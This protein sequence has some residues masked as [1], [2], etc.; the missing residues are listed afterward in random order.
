MKKI[1]GLTLVFV[2]LVSLLAV[3]PVAAEG[4]EDGYYA[5]LD[6]GIT[7]VHRCGGN[8]YSVSVAAKEIGE[9]KTFECGCTES[10]DN[11]LQGLIDKADSSDA[12]K[13]VAT[14]LLNYGAAAKA[15]FGYTGADIFG[16]PAT[17]VTALKAANA[18]DVEITDPNGIYL[19]ATL[20][21]DGTM[22]IRFF[23]NTADVEIDY[24]GNT[25][26]VDVD[27]DRPGVYY[28]DVNVMPYAM[29]DYAT[30]E[31]T[32][33]VAA[34]DENSEEETD[35][36]TE[37]DAPAATVIKYSP[38]NYLQAKADDP[39][40]S[41]MVASI[42]AYGE[43]AYAYYYEGC[44]VYPMDGIVLANG[45]IDHSKTYSDKKHN[46]VAGG[47][48]K[49]ALI[50]LTDIDYDTVT[51]TP[52]L[53]GETGF[54]AFLTTK[55]TTHDT[56]VNYALNYNDM[57]ELND[58]V[59]LIIPENAKYLVVTNNYDNGTSCLPNTIVFSDTVTP[60]DN[61]K[62]DALTTYE[63]PVDTIKPSQ[64][65][66]HSKS[67]TFISNFDWISSIVSLEDTVFNQ[68]IFE[69]G[70]N[71]WVGYAFLTDYPTIDASIPFA[72]KD[73]NW[74]WIEKEPGTKVAV[75]IP[76]NAT[77]MLLCWHEPADE[78]GHTNFI[79]ASMTFTKEGN[80]VDPLEEL[81]DN[82]LPKYE[83]PMNEV[84]PADGVIFYWKDGHYYNTHD[85]YRVAFIE[86]TGTVFDTVTLTKNLN[87][88]KVGWA[89]L[90]KMPA[91]G[92]SASYATGY[93]TFHWSDEGYSPEDIVIPK[94]ATYLAVYYQDSVT[95]PFC[96]ETITF[97]QSTYS[98]PMDQLTPVDGYFNRQNN[99]S[100][101]TP[102]FKVSTSGEN[103]AFVDLTNLDYNTVTLLGNANNES[104]WYTFVTKRPINNDE[105]ISYA[106]NC[107]GANWFGWGAEKD[108]PAVPVTVTI[109]DNAAY[110]VVLYNYNTKVPT[111]PQSIV[112]SNSD[113]T[114]SEMLKNDT[115]DS[116]EY[117]MDAIKPSMGTIRGTDNVF[118]QNYQWV[119][120]Y[121]GIEDCV[122]DKVTFEIGESGKMYYAF[123]TA[124]PTLDQVVS[125]AGGATSTTEL[126]GAVGEKIS[127]SIPDDAVCLYIY[128]HDW[129]NG[130]PDYMLPA[131]VTFGKM[132]TL[133]KLQDPIRD[134][135]SYP[136]DE[137]TSAGGCVIY[138]GDG[139]NR[140]LANYN[141]E[142]VGTYQCAFIEITD[143]VFNYVTMVS[144]GSKSVGWAF[145]S[146]RPG[147]GEVAQY[148][149]HQ[150]FL[151]SGSD[152]SVNVEI[153][154]GANY[155]A[156]WYIES[157]NNYVPS[158]IL[159]SK[160]RIDPNRAFVGE[161][162]QMV[163]P[164]DDVVSAGGCVIYWD[165]N[166]NT[167]KDGDHLFLEN[168]YNE[169]VGKYQCAVIDISNRSSALKYV[170]ITPNGKKVAGYA[171]LSERPEEGKAV[172]YVG[173]KGFNWTGDKDTAKK[174]ITI[175]SGAKYLVV[176]YEEAGN[177]YCPASIIFTNYKK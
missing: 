90:T 95:E 143:T 160:E 126:T 150:G 105:K 122:F 117:P 25:L 120:S 125:F 128:R 154:D 109:P 134:E 93:E 81:R 24:D 106:M 3:L 124:Y 100:N 151:W 92:E 8:E 60:A 33:K 166:G 5:Y 148:V 139:G 176:W 130:A 12:T 82:T 177:D 141:N 127:V 10:V 37:P 138:W 19:G 165:E 140:F 169:G 79:P 7:L 91:L 107:S 86:I 159:F 20:V 22:K 55:P 71:G 102:T 1:L 56:M 62:N 16:T 77:C 113:T 73:A 44:Y 75:D 89:F 6:Q 158:N 42:Y 41:A 110:M 172:K 167:I 31:A 47:G 145:L 80:V 53:D 13:A 65:T 98:Y 142:G 175:P 58:E 97:K 54:Y 104:G 11:Y 46:F 136:M 161:T 163:Y 174:N 123:L 114:P 69:V 173:D 116:Y 23:F 83:Y 61:L 101:K 35:D 57:R 152:S 84:L 48:E 111:Y 157:G 132:T 18:W 72:T 87:A 30:V 119:G 39:A 26:D 28:F 51:L 36:T 21:L 94:G 156:L 15:Y 112:F 170:T 68:V 59:T 171:F 153:P 135:F 64:G 70:E 76:R 74:S 63:Y 144:G 149:G 146:N 85:T 66:I 147:E 40:L 131:S 168:A 96:P 129:K 17:D 78:G 164:M 29:K 45:T 14:A 38:L 115:L 34:A 9:T 88:D 49:I 50:D 27:E 103:I 118:I 4:D 108:Q 133:D 32:L 137:V 52:N 67:G 162:L 121:V 99:T 155:L 43:A 2:M